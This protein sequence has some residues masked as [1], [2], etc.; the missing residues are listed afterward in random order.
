M[1]MEAIQER[2]AALGARLTEHW[3]PGLR[4][5][6]RLSV[7]I[8]FGM[9]TM[10][11]GCLG[12]GVFTAGLIAPSF[13]IH[14][15]VAAGDGNAGDHASLAYPVSTTAPIA[16]KTPQGQRIAA[17]AVTATATPSPT[18]TPNATAIPTPAPTN[19]PVPCPAITTGQ[20][21]LQ[22]RTVRDGTV[23]TPMIAGCPAILYISAPTL[24]N[25]PIVISLYFGRSYTTPCTIN[26]T[27][28]QTDSAGTAQITFTVPAGTCILGRIMTTG[29]ISVGGDSSAN[30]S[31]PANSN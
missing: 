20:P 21:T 14:L 8:T 24:P 5:H 6:R 30:A 7:I 10:A 22:G 25:A 29:V 3:G 27:D 1:H 16:I 18:A 28:N 23:P 26:L 9:L 17:I 11:L 4:F 13:F 2:L 31:L 12:V 19:T 15:Q